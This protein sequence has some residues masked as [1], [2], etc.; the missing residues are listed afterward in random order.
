M[1]ESFYGQKE[2]NQDFLS[3]TARTAYEKMRKRQKI[4]DLVN[5]IVAMISIFVV[6]YESEWFYKEE[7]ETND[8]GEE[9]ITKESNESDDRI[10]AMRAFNMI[11]SGVIV[12]LIYKHY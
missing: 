11:L 9:E 6:Y 12:F 1:N 7:T 2:A 3:N 5:A 4:W 8:N 10:N